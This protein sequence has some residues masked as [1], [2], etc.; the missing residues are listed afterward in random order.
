MPLM[1]MPLMSRF[2]GAR[3]TLCLR[4]AVGMAFDLAFRFAFGLA[5]GFVIFMPGM[6]RMSCP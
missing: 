2:F 1:F 5:F 4:R 6:S 3:R